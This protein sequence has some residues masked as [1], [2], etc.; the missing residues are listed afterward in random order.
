MIA[1]LRWVHDNIQAFGGDPD[2]VSLAGHGIGS[3]FVHLLATSPLAKGKRCHEKATKQ[4]PHCFTDC[5][6][7][8][9][10]LLCIQNEVPLFE[11]LFVLRGMK[12]KHKKIHLYEICLRCRKGN[13]LFKSLVLSF[14][15]SL[16]EHG[17]AAIHVH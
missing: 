1:V 2:R 4:T 8:G 3:D 6:T 16:L 11:G 7:W 17:Y 9:F 12:I 15:F 10:L 5:V 14:S 13:L